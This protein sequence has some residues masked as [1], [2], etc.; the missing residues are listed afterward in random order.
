MKIVMDNGIYR[1][2]DV[3]SGSKNGKEYQFRKLLFIDG[4]NDLELSCDAGK[5]LSK[6][7]VNQPSQITL[8]VTSKKRGYNIV[9]AL[10]RVL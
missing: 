6:L 3:I 10:D 7:K 9:M 8:E 5:D 4:S 2:M 1:G